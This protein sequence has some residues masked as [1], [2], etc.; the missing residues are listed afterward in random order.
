MWQGT[1][2]PSLKKNYIYIFIYFT[3]IPPGPADN[4]VSAAAD[5]QAGY[6]DTNWAPR[7]GHFI[8]QS[9]YRH[10]HET[11]S[12]FLLFTYASNI[13]GWICCKEGSALP[14]ISWSL[15]NTVST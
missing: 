13:S 10:T 6:L 4:D 1:C 8:G 5:L 15:E 14:Q 7:V 12:G 11:P 9:L 3:F 2:E